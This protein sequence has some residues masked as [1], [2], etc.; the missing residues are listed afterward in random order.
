MNGAQSYKHNC[1]ENSNNLI[2]L[3]IIRITEN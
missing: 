2:R 1:S 3:E